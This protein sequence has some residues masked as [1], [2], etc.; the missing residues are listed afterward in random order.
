[1]LLRNLDPKSKIDGALVS[2]ASPSMGRS[3][4]FPDQSLEIVEGHTPGAQSALRT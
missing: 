2:V 3:V 1:M 4:T